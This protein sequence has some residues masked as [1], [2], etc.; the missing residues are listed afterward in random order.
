MEVDANEG[1]LRYFEEKPKRISPIRSGGTLRERHGRASDGRDRVS[2]RGEEGGGRKREQEGGKERESEG[3]KRRRESGGEKRRESEGRKRSESEGGKRRGIKIEEDDQN[4]DRTDR[5]K[6]E[7]T[8]H[9]LG[10]QRDQQDR[11]RVLSDQGEYANRGA[12]AC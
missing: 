11:G 3:G 9:S 8:E 5:F 7:Q 4:G 6:N 12:C 1:R 2:G 10:Q